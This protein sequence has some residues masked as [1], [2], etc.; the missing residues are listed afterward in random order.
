MSL[1]IF[2]EGDVDEDI[3]V[4]LIPPTTWPRPTYDG[5]DRYRGIR[6]EKMGSLPGS[7]TEATFRML[8]GY[9]LLN[10]S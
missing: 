1:F 3:P 5:Q 7:S 8:P 2:E 10:D 9:H 4:N 6:R